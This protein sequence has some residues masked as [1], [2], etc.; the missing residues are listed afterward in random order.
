[1]GAMER[2][3]KYYSVPAKRGG[4][5]IYR[6]GDPAFRLRG[7]ILSSDGSHLFVRMHHSGE[8]I[9]FHPTWKIQYLP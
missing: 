5:I 8:R 7:T 3:R 1:M 2:V 6:P 4:E 9:R